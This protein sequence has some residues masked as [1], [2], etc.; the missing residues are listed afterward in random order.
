LRSSFA[1]C[2]YLYLT[3]LPIVTKWWGNLSVDGW[4]N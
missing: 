1:M 2:I 4:H 3:W